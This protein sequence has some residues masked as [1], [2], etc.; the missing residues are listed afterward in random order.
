M[1][2]RMNSAKRQPLQFSL[3][4]LLRVTMWV[5]FLLAIY[6]QDK[7]AMSK[8]RERIEALKAAGQLPGIRQSGAT[9]VSHFAPPVVP[10]AVPR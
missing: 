6:L 7:H 10:A 4:T 9:P 2:E 5:A 3:R 1:M 8:H